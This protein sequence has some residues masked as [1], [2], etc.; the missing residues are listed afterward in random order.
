MARA[1]TVARV[2][3]IEI[4]FNWRWA[5]VVLL[6]TW[7]LA[8]DVLP[9]RFPT[10]ELSTS[11]ITA[12]AAVLAGEAALLLHELSHALLARC[13]GQRVQR[14]VFHGFLAETIVDDDLAQAEHT[15]MIALVGPAANLLL[16]VAVAGLR[17][18]L[19]S[20]G[21]LDAFLLMF[22]IGN[23]AAAGLSLVPLGKSDG[24]RALHALRAPLLQGFWG[25]EAEVA[26]QR[27]N[28]H[29]QDQQP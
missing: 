1:V 6:G 16:A 8:H 14:I 7:L 11:W 19:S 21:A 18:A 10:W 24:A 29:D 23:A 2:Q 28:E 26:G 5:P 9:A 12:G 17:L 22:L 25:L 4:A 27:Q 15:V 3:T 13:Y 20:Q